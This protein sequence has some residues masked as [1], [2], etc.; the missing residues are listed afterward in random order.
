MNQVPYGRGRW[1][2]YQRL[3]VQRGGLVAN[4]ALA[5]KPATRFWQVM[6]K[7][8][9]YVEHGLA[10]YEVKVLETK[11]RALRRLAAQLG[12]QLMPLPQPP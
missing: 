12:Q 1:R 8:M 4:I 10:A 3:A 2:F 5:R 11:Q 6:V 7:G 9:D